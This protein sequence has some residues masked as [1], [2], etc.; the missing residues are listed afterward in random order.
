M[1][2]VVPLLL[3]RDIIGGGRVG[4]TN[5][6]ATQ[7]LS[8][9]KSVP[10]GEGV[11]YELTAARLDGDAPDAMFGR[12]FVQAN[13]E[14]VALGV[15]YSRASRAEGGPGVARAFVA[16]SI[17]GVGGRM[18]AA[19]PIQDSFALVR[20]PD[21]KDV[22]VYANGWLA[23]RTDASGEVIATNIASYYDNFISFGTKEMPLDYYLPE[24][25]DRDLAAHAQWNARFL[26]SPQ[27]SRDRRVCWWRLVMASR[28]HSS[29]AS[30]G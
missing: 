23:G 30:S 10:Q 7:T 5:N 21:L 6:G 14:H 12:A 28:R 20:I 27:E 15:E 22:P 13:A 17:G 9:Q 19:R 29:S 4:R 1:A 3:R 26:R 18:F 11:G 2:V 25:G 16:G 8:L 24:L